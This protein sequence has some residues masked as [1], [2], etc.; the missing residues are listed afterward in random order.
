MAFP[1]RLPG[2][3][4][5]EREHDLHTRASYVNQAGSITVITIRAAS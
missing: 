1:E 3:V 5:I 4:L 2:V